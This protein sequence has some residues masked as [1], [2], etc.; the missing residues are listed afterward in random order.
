LKFATNVATGGQFSW[1]TPIDRPIN[2]AII[3]ASLTTG[4]LG[5]V[6]MA[7]GCQIGDVVRLKS[8]GP[9]M[10]VTGFDP[11]NNF[12][13][14]GYFAGTDYK[15]MRAGGAA[16]VKVSDAELKAELDSQRRRPG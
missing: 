13:C 1:N 6:A 10:T 14:C 9:I 3:G 16:F 12:P 8:G 7:E 2:L 11:T 15:E 4:C 5:G